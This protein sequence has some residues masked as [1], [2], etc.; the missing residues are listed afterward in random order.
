MYG[1]N[2]SDNSTTDNG[3]GV[4]TFGSLSTF[5]MYG[6]S[7]SGNTA[8]EHG[9]GVYIW[10]PDSFTVSGSVNITG[11]NKQFL[12]SGT[13]PDNVYLDNGNTIA[14]GGALTNEALIGVYTKSKPT[15]DNSVAITGANETDYINNFTSDDT[16]YE[17]YNDSS[18]N[19]IKIKKY[20]PMNIP[21]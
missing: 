10:I 15:G 19:T 20:I 17:I 14:I 1:G 2:I 21:E 16:Y 13:T 7:I 6:G 12:P 18:N 4:N 3:G 8:T 5:N 9:G 11:N